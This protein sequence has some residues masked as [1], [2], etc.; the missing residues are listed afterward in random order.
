MSRDLLD[1]ARE[2]A[3]LARAAG[4]NEVRAE[5]HRSRSSSVEWID[6]E[7]D[8]VRESTEMGLSAELF[9]DGRYAVHR[10]SD[11]RTDAVRSF[12]E[13]AVAMTRL[14]AADTHRRLPDPSRYVQPERRDLG[15][16][17]PAGLGG[18]SGAGRRREAQAL[19][20][21][22]R[23]APGGEMIVSASASVRDREY[24]HAMVI[25][26]GMEGTAAATTFSISADANIRVNGDER[27]RGYDFAMS[28]TRRDLPPADRIGAEAMRRALSGLGARSLSTGEHPFILENRCA[29]RIFG[30]V[31]RAL[32]GRS[33]HQNQTFLAG[34]LEERIA[35]PILTVIDEPHI[36]GGFSSRHYDG[37]G[38]A[39]RRMPVIEN[40]VLRNFYIDTYYASRLGVTPTTGTQTNLRLSTGTRD[41][42]GLLQAM[43]TGILVTDFVGGNSNAL[44]GDFSAGIRGQWVENGVIVHPIIEM[45]LSGSLQG[46]LMDLEEMGNDV[47]TYGGTLRPSMRFSKGL[48]SGA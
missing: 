34:K 1:K 33:I 12:L 2:Y 22:V 26:N 24:Q 45:N 7:L 40:G 15:L 48:F 21:A 18:S 14:L 38:M 9:V 47:Y 4:A 20:D 43:G 37:E 32:T 41:L 17:D 36:H 29:G 42:E 11:L 19:E 16:H 31:G 44:T 27:Q 6:G 30:W 25:S 28:R 3:R 23:A 8:R 35:S 39:S 5:V 46:L 13:E 10:T